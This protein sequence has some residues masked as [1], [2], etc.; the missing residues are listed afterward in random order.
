MNIDRRNFMLSSAAVGVGTLTSKPSNAASN[1]I[2]SN[3][4]LEK[5]V[6]QKVLDT[7]L[8]KNPVMIDSLELLKSGSFYIVRARSKEGAEGIAVANGKAATLYP[9]FQKLVAPYFIG[10]DARDLES[11]LEGVYVHASNYKLQSPALWCPVAWVEFSLLDLMGK[12]ANRHVS[13]FFGG[14]LRDEIEFYIASGNRNTTAEEEAEILQQLVE[15]HQLKAVKFKVGGRMSHNADSIPGRSEKLIPLVRK[16]L[17]DEIEIHADSNGSY[18]AE[19]GI[20]IGK[21]L[22]DIHAHFFEEPCPFDYLEETKQV[23]DAIDIPIAGGEQESSQRRFQWMIANQAVQIVQPDLHYYGGMIRATR[24][25]RMAAAA[26]MPITVHMSG[27]GT[28]YVDVLNFSSFTPNIGAFQEYKG[29]LEETGP[30]YDPPLVRKDSKISAP[31]G[32]G[33]GIRHDMDVI[34]NAKPIS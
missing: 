16:T 15:E 10:K 13:A 30:W 29:G 22:E 34:R 23:A 17:G 33:M 4:E 25:G 14:R 2:P 3:E 6:N 12:I 28:G 5:I 19:N 27:G 20:R 18:D 11:L 31:T 24:V 26:G 8:L 1:S 32:A 21:M 9:I 7:S